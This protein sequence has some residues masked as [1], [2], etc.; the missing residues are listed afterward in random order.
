MTK[1]KMLRFGIVSLAGI[2]REA[3]D[4][5][6]A[7]DQHRHAQLL[8]LAFLHGRDQRQGHAGAG[9]GSCRRTSMPARR[10]RS[11]MRIEVAEGTEA[12]GFPR[13]VA[14][15]PGMTGIYSP[16]HLTIMPGS[17]RRPYVAPIV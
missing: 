14:S 16:P 3:R 15:R 8:V 5:R 9:T 11:L 12:R 13:P 4:L 10:F 7:G 2:A 17:C 1:D 6:R